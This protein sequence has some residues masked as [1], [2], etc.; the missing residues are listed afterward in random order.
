MYLPDGRKV[1]EWFGKAVKTYPSA[2]YERTVNIPEDWNGKEIRLVCEYVNDTAELLINGKKVLSPTDIKRNTINQ[3]IDSALEFGKTNLFR[4]RVD[5]DGNGR[6]A[7]GGLF[8]DIYLK[9]LPEK[10]M[11]TPIIRTSLEHKNITV[12]F[13]NGSNAGGTAYISIVDAQS[14]KEVFKSEVPFQSQIKLPFVT[15]KLWSCTSPNL[16]IMKLSLK[17]SSGKITDSCSIRFGF[18]ELK[19][20]KD[21]FILNNKPLVLKFDS[22]LK[23]FWTP[24]W[25]FTSEYFRRELKALTKMNLNSMY[26]PENLPNELYSIADEEGILLMAHHSYPYKEQQKSSTEEILKRLEKELSADSDDKKFYNHPAFAG[27]LI[28][29]WFN[30]HNGTTNP[31]FVGL[32][33]GT[34]SYPTFSEEG[35]IV[36]KTGRDPNLS[37]MR[38]ERK[39]RLE[40]MAEVYHRYFPDTLC[41]TGGSGEVSGIYATHI[42][43]TW[44]APPEELRAL[45]SRWGMQREL[46]LFIGESTLP[47][48]G[49]FYTIHD[50]NA[51]KGSNPLYKENFA[52]LA[53]NNAYRFKGV[54]GRR[55]LHDH[56]P[57]SLLAN[58]REKA[59]GKWY[60]FPADIYMFSL[61]K[62]LNDTVTAWRWSGVNGFGMFCYVLNQ[63]FTLAEHTVDQSKYRMPEDLSAPGLKSEKPDGGASLPG[64][65]VVGKTPDYRPTTLAVPFRQAM[66]DVTCDI[67]GAGRDVFE[68]DHAWFGGDVMKKTLI[69]FN[70]TDKEHKYGMTVSL[71]NDFG[72]I[73]S[74]RTENISVALFEHKKLPLSMPLPNVT[75]R[76][77]SRLSVCLKP[78]DSQNSL[79]KANLN[80]QIFPRPTKQNISN[81]EILLYDPE[82]KLTSAMKK[83]GYQLKTLN[84][85]KSLPE[86]GILI[87]GRKALSSSPQVPDFCQLAE[88]GLNSLIMEQEQSASGELMQVRTRTAF[89]NAQGHPVLQNFRNEDFTNW[90]GSFSILPAY[91]NPGPGANWTDWGNRNMLAGLAF[92]RPA[93][94]NYL[95]LLVN[96]F[97]LFQSPLLEYRGASASWLGSQLEITDR[98]NDDPV[99]T[100]LLVSMINYLDQ[101]GKTLSKTAFF[102]KSTSMDFLQRMQIDCKEITEPNTA[103]LN[104][105]DTLIIAEPDWNIL[106]KHRFD[107]NTFVY[108]GGKIFYLQQGKDFSSSWLPFPVSLKTAETRQALCRGR[109]DTLWRCGWDNNDLYWHNKYYVPV[110]ADFPPQSDATDPAVILRRRYGSG[111][112]ILCSITPE[113][114]PKSPAAGKITRMLSVLMTDC[115][116]KINGNNKSPYQLKSTYDVNIDLAPLRWEF[117]LDP[118]DVGLKENWEKG[119]NGTGNWITG[120]VD[121]GLEVLVGQPFETFIQKQYDGCAWYRINVELPEAAAKAQN[122]YFTAGA[123]DDLD[124]VFING[125][126]IGETGENTPQ[127]WMASRRYKIPVGLIKPGKNLI[128]VRVI[129]QRGDGGIVKLPLKLTTRATKGMRFWSTPY[130]DGSK[131]DYEY[132][133]DLIRMY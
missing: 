12:D 57:D 131:R 86:K 73:I 132:K 75:E 116:T 15:P 6:S 102:G 37:G 88:Q 24:D 91:G 52:R 55:P 13:L 43:H 19:V 34:K 112:F 53:G 45:F 5:S 103:E 106:N 28:D 111:S 10:N 41:F 20:V 48:Q 44:G 124:Q 126:K 63:H 113:L 125:V 101:R 33:D 78:L 51:G 32:K 38:L 109:A 59:D 8:G 89:I 115:G 16:Y 82:G 72:D 25:Q 1:E 84:S 18:R 3:R 27:F 97:D 22:G 67:F 65:D 9:V 30:Y 74:S 127:Y 11:G 62:Y 133:S 23:G 4:I 56:D 50:F 54:Y 64:F 2:W 114:F 118:K 60:Y 66:A 99:A 58:M 85:L 107:I 39:N 94:G 104:Q 87:I 123:I 70:D 40:K 7:R 61:E 36:H 93:H 14:N 121:D 95:S 96:G 128:A 26:V 42:Y 29:I 130:P 129:D 49:A 76:T 17:T 21:K 47:Y 98:I 35:K 81:K 110:F 80:L 90:K 108:N 100:H 119:K 77:N 46:P 69:T 71:H 122:L 79:L 117:S 83:L 92:R 68:M 105:F 31:A 120:L